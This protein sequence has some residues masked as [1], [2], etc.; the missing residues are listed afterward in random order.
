[1]V[2]NNY[3]EGNFFSLNIHKLREGMKK[4][5]WIKDV[6]IYRKWPNRITMLITQHQPI[7]RYGMQ[8][9]INEEGE[10]FGAAYEDYLPIIYLSLIHI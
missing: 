6:D 2:A 9:L 7:A 4:L 1:M 8:G 10:F 3:L 5:P